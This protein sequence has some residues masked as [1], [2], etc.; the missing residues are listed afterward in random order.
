MS[1]H[2]VVAED[3]ILVREGLLRML[4]ALPDVQVVGAGGSLD[5]ALGLIDTH[6]PDVVLTDIR[7]PPSRSDEGLRIAEHCRVRHPGTGV[8]LLSQYVEV[9]YVR[10]LLQRGTEG[11]GY[12]L[13]ERIA[14]LDDLH[15]AITAV[16]AGGSA[17]D[18]KVIESL[19]SV[20]SKGGDQGLAKLSPRELEVLGA[21]AQGRTNKAVATELFLTQRAV[22]KH[23][24]SIFAKLGLTGDQSTHPRVRA[25]LLYLAGEGR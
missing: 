2:L 9:G 21:V 23:I 10:V 1:L 14:D 3:S 12:L 7:M 22:E 24:N 17:I 15:G 18:P 19:V 8:V 25:A 5:D 13:K 11:R 20:R 16:A 6:R 4:S